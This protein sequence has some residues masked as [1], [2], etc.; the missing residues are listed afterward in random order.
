MRKK[1]AEIF[2]ATFPPIGESGEVK[3]AGT[4]LELYRTARLALAFPGEVKG[5]GERLERMLRYI[6]RGKLGQRQSENQLHWGVPLQGA[7]CG[8]DFSHQT[9]H[10]GSIT[11][12]GSSQHRLSILPSK[13]NIPGSSS[14]LLHLH[15][16]L[17]LAEKSCHGGLGASHDL[18]LQ[19]CG[20]QFSCR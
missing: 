15:L 10:V 3:L 14:R 13:I 7:Q 4:S 20:R 17:G 1:V 6:H 9:A 2:D 16:D 12:F 18:H 5:R 8:L 19:D 11:S